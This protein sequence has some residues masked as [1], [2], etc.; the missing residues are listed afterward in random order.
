[1][2]EGQYFSASSHDMMM[3]TLWQSIAGV[4]TASNYFQPAGTAPAPSTIEKQLAELDSLVELLDPELVKELKEKVE[5]AGNG[6]PAKAVL[7]SAAQGLGDQGQ[8]KFDQFA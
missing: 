3:L 7:V 5:G 8:G 4:I 6:E 2:E 1:M